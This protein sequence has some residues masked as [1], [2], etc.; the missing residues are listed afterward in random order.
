MRSFAALRMTADLD[1]IRSA[2]AIEKPA[3]LTAGFSFSS[4]LQLLLI[5]TWIS[6]ARIILA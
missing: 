3:G 2:T 1:D 4:R 5:L 6:R